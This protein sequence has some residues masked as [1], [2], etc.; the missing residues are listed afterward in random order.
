M[1][2]ARD[3][4]Y[5][6]ADPNSFVELSPYVEAGA[7]TGYA[8]IGGRLCFMF[9]Q[10]G[11][12]GAAHAGK[13]ADVYARALETGSPVIGVYDS[14][15]VELCEALEVAETYGRVLKAQRLAKG[16]IPQ[17]GF[18]GGVCKGMSALVAQGSDFVFLADTGELRLQSPNVYKWNEKPDKCTGLSDFNGNLETLA[19]SLRKLLNL[20]P[21][22]AESPAP[23]RENGDD[24]DRLVAVCGNAQ[25]LISGICDNGEFLGTDGGSTG[26][27][28]GF[29]YVNDYTAGIIC[30]A[31]EATGDSLRRAARFVSTCDSFNIPLIMLTGPEGFANGSWDDAVLLERSVRYLYALYGARVPK[32]CVITTGA[33]QSRLLAC[34][35]GG[36][37]MV[38]AWKGARIA[39]MPGDASET[40]GVSAGDAVS[41]AR[42]G[43]VDD[44]IEP[45]ETRRRIIAALEMLYAKRA[46]KIANL[47]GRAL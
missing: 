20:L 38:F 44:V 4:V 28:T 19:P 46:P 9:C 23:F 35:R 2:Q 21:Q 33:C 12:V 8:A 27:V 34:C 24:P 11:P 16:K 39:A 45:S 15:G 37:D 26:V 32:V 42:K 13:I 22:N 29:G 47:S 5:R 40:Y 25:S 43:F 7:I 6:L 41:A 14:A 31:G 3:I 30:E 18:I 10:E 17:I 36:A 1:G